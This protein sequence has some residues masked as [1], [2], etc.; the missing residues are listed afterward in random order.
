VPDE[1]TSDRPRRRPVLLAMLVAA[2]LLVAIAGSGAVAG[3][4]SS[5]SSDDS[6]GLTRDAP[7][8]GQSQG[9]SGFTHN[10]RHCRHGENRQAPQQSPTGQ[11]PV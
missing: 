9:G 5:R 2:A 7:A 11:P 3:G 4:G 6:T 10:G 1:P 8:A